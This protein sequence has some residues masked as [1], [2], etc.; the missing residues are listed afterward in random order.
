[1]KALAC[2]VTVRPAGVA[3][4]GQPAAQ[5]PINPWF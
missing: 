2:E 5:M 1:M 3:P 4:A